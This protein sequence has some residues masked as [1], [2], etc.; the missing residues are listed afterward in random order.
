MK[1]VLILGGTQFIG[2]NLVEHLLH[3]GEWDL[4]LFNRQ[5]TH[6]DLFPQV[7][8][9]RGDRET[10]DIDQLRSGNWDC[11]IDLSAYYPDSFQRLVDLLN[12]RVDR[13]VFVS[14]LSAL[15]PSLNDELVLDE[16]QPTLDCDAGQR[17][18]MTVSS[19]GNRKAECERVLQRTDG[20]DHVILRPSLVYG[21]HDPTDR[22]YY[23]L[24]RAH[25]GLPILLPDAGIDAITLTYVRDLVKV[26]LRSLTISSHGFVYN[27]VTHPPLSLSAMLGEWSETVNA[28]PVEASKLLS[29]GIRPGQD[30]PLW[31]GGSFKVSQEKLIRDFG[32]PFTSFKQSVVETSRYYESLGWPAP[33]VGLSSIPADVLEEEGGV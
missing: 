3:S 11:V 29:L 1:S 19:Y 15:R 12:G 33:K 16:H 18:D 32:L 22:F 10:A 23:W 21:Q 9:L 17:V 20:L 26:L 28:I 31:F 6:S 13:Y 4:T 2:R 30:I 8:K 7:K 27:V 24:Y 5:K 25:K 14:T